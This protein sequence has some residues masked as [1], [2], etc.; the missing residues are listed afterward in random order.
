[1]SDSPHVFPTL[2]IAGFQPF[3]PGVALPCGAGVAV[4]AELLG[5]L[6][7]NVT[8][9]RVASHALLDL[10]EDIMHMKPLV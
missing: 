9:V 8:V 10:N 1:M 2:P 3:D 7:K 4:G 6:S 5:Y